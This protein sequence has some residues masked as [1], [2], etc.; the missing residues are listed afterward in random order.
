VGQPEPNPPPEISGGYIWSPKRNANGARNPFY[1]TIREVAPGD[2]VFSFVDTRIAAI[3]IVQSYCWES[4]NPQ[5]FGTTGEYWENIGWKVKVAFTP[6]LRRIRP[7]D[8]MEFLRPLLPAKYS[9]LQSSG[10]GLHG[11]CLAEVS[12]P[13]AEV[14]AGHLLPRTR[15]AGCP[16]QVHAAGNRREEDSTKTSLANRC[17][18][19]GLAPVVV[20]LCCRKPAD[21][22]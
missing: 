12:Q 10:Y 20:A 15:R 17:L 14:L 4:P 19:A 3:G 6:L 8:H 1:E 7:K 18:P 13:L 16:G 2:V 21:P 22:H 5:E 9:P 11:I